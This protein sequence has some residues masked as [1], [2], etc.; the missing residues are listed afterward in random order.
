[1]DR[2]TLLTTPAATPA[3]A[4]GLDTAGLADFLR[5]YFA[6]LFLVVVSVVALVFLFTR[7][8]TRFVQFML[9]S[10]A[11]GVIFYVPDIIEVLAKG[12]GAAL[13]VR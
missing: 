11:I 12:V 2:G 1:M 6:P 5:S 10:V 8:L 7:E 3:P 4:G 9:V 13:G